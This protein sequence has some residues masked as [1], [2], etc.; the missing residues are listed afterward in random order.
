MISFGF[1][2]PSFYAA[3]YCLLRGAPLLIY[4]DGTHHAEISTLKRRQIWARG[5]LLRMTGAC[6]ALEEAGGG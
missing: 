6:V 3:G 1:S 4:S 2:I 5:L